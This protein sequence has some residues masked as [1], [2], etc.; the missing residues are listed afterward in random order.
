[1]N[2]K[3]LTVK[4][5]GYPEP[6]RHMKG[7]P[8]QLY[9]SGEPLGQLLNKPR[10]TIVG[11]RQISIYGERVTRQL[12]KQLAEQDVVIISGL[13]FGVDAVAH[14]AALEVGGCCIAVLPS[15]LDNIVPVS[16]ARLADKILAG[17]GA[18]V[19][20]YAPGERPYKQN[21]IA[22]NRIMSGLG[23]VVLVT[24]ARD[25]S[26]TAHTSRFALEQGIDVL[27]VPG[28]I[29]DLGSV[30]TNNLIKQGAR[31]VTSVDDILHA[32][33]LSNH[34]TPVKQVRGRNANEQSILDLMLSGI[35]DADVLLDRCGL[36]VPPFNQALT[37]LHIDGKVRPIGANHWVIS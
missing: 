12:A 33:G 32:I 17:G 16:N 18:L 30:G 31:I 14:Q 21:F 25:K 13:A 6:L 4:D 11:T 1:M 7:R 27:A 10:V 2:I 19:S 20:E 5:S 22:R 34:N 3:K 28:N 37:M 29:Y 24:E 15:P 36:E 23:Q 26:G 8:K 35:T 9:C